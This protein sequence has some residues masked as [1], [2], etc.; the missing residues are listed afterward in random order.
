MKKLVSLKYGFVL[1]AALILLPARVEAKKK[2]KPE[3][4]YKFTIEVEYPRTATK[5]QG[6]SSTC[7]SYSA[8]SFLESES[9][10]VGKPEVE[11][12]VMYT[13]RNIYI[14]KAEQFVRWNGKCEFGPGGADHDVINS[15]KNTESSHCRYTPAIRSGKTGWFTTRWMEFSGLTPMGSSETLTASSALPGKPGSAASRMFISERFRRALN[16]REPPTHQ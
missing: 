9:M 4:P 10:R 15:I 3:P 14:D 13:V 2:K 7:W 12:S 11:L 6:A 1:M 16:I 5:N 8:T